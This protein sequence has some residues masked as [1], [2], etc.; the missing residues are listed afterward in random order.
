MGSP[1]KAELARQ[2]EAL[3][4]SLGRQ[5]KK[6]ARLEETLAEALE[7]QAATSEILRVIS[8]SPTDVQPV[9]D[10]IVANAA[11]LCDAEFS[12]V[13]RFEGGLLH[14]VAINNM[15]RE[16]TAAYQSLFP[17][18][19]G[20]HFAIGRAFVD[21]R[22]AHIEDVSKD[23]DY[24]PRTLDVLQRAA[25]Y[26]TYL[27]I[28]IMRDGVPIGA[29]GCGRRKVKPFTPA[30][31]E[32]VK[33]FADQAVIAIENVRLFNEAE[34][35]NR[36]LAEALEQQKATAEVLQV[37]SSSPTDIQPV[38]DTVAE[39]AAH[40]C[41]AFDAAI[42]RRDGDSLRLVAH[43]GA[44]PLG[45]LGQF[46]LPI[47]RGSMP[48]RSMLDGRT[49]HV[50]DLQV[51]SVEFP[52]GAEI[53]QRYGFRTT[54]CV[55]MMRD[56]AALGV[57]VLRRTE[58]EP[59]TA[60]QVALLQTF[61]DQAVIAIENVRLF[62]ELDARNSELRTA[63][64]QQTAT[65]ELLKVIGQSTF[66]LQPVFETLAENA[67]RLC[68]AE[69]ASIFR[70]DGHLLRIVATRNLPSELRAFL[71]QHPIPLARN[72]GSGRAALERRTIHIHDVRSDPEYAYRGREVAPYRTMVAIPMLRAAELLGVIVV[73]R[74]EV[75]PFTDGHIALMETFADQAAIAIENARLLT[76]L[77]AKNADL[78]EA[79][80][81]QTAT[82]EILRVISS[83][84]TDIR[85]VLDTVTE[86]AARLCE[87]VDTA[88]FFRDG[89]RLRLAAHHGAIVVGTI[90]VFTLPL[91]RGIVGARSVLD[92]RTIHVADMQTEGDEFPESSENA[93]RMGFRTILC[94]PLMREGV[95]IGWIQLR[96]TDMRLFTDRQVALLETFA[97]QAVIAIENV[98]LFTELEARNSE[99][100]VALEQQ[101]ATSEVLKVISRSTFDLQ[102][103][104]ETLVE[105]ASRL[106]GA[107]GALIARFDGEVFRFLAEYGASPEFSEYWRRHVIRPGRGSVVGRAILERRTVHIVDA[108]ADPEFEYYE[109][110][111]AGGYRS[112]LAVPMLRE[113]DLI[114]VFFMWRT[115]VRAFTDKQIDLVATFAD[116]AV[117]AIENSR[118]LTELTAKNADLTVALEQQTATSEILRVISSSP[119]DVQPVFDTIVR[120][121]VRLCDGLF[122]A[123]FLYD[124][125]LIDQVAQHNFSPEGLAEVRRLYPTRPGPGLGSTR[126]IMERAVVHIPDVETDPEYQHLGLTRAV[127]MR[128]GL[129]VPMLREGATVGVIMVSRA[130]PGRFADDQVE[131]LKTFADQ[132]VIAIQNVRLFKEL[133]ARNAELRVAL[134]QQTAT[135]EILR[136]ISSSPTDIQPVLDTVAESAARLCEAQ[137]AAIF[138]RDGDRLLLVA[139]HGP[140][141]YGPVGDFSLPLVPG[142]ANG[143]AVLDARTIHVADLQAAVDEFPDGS[144]TARRYGH[145]TVLNV[146]L[147]REG[148]AI[149]S[150]SLRRSEIQPFTEQQVALLQ[151]FADQAVIAIENV[152]LFNELQ[153]R[154][155]DLTEALEQQ[156]ATAEILRAISGSPTDVQPVF[157]AIVRS[158]VQLSGARFGALYRFDGTLLH[159]V[160]H[161]NLTPDALEALQ[162]AYPMR[163]SRAQVSGRAILGRAVAEIPD[164]WNDPEYLQDMARHAD[165][166]S[167]LAVPMLRADGAPIGAIVIQ[168]AEPGPF[169][170]GHVG[171]LK[172]FADQA[173]IAIE[174]VRLFT[175]LEAR[176]SELRV[177]LEQQTATSELL[178]VIGRSTFD[179]EPVFEALAE[180]AVR[181]CDAERAIIHRFDGHVLR[182]AVIHN[183]TPELRELAE[184]THLEPGRGTASGR[185]ALERRTVHIHDVQIDP[186]YTFEAARL[187][188]PIRTALAIP[189]LRA[190]EL[191]G[192]IFIY[193]HEV[194]PFSDS[195]I[196]LME[197]FADQAAIAIEN[198]R[199]LT[200]LQTKNT[201][202]TEALEQQTATSEILRVISSSPTDVQPVFDA[203]V[204]SAVR[205]CGGRFGTLYR[206]YGDM[207]D[208]VAYYNVPPE[209]YDLLRRGFPR[210]TMAGTSPHFRRALLEGTVESIRD[211]DTDTELS[212]RVLGF[213]RHHDMR[214][215]VMVPLRAQR[216]VVGVL[217]VGHREVAAFSDSHTAL[218]QTFADQAVIAIENVRLFRELEARNSELRVALEQ[219]TAT[220]EL[221]K[222]IG[223]STFDLQ[224]VF[225]MLAENAVRLCEAERAVILR[226]DGRL[227]H[228]V[229]THNVSAELRAYIE[230]NPIAPGRHS[231]AA[232]AALERRTIHIEDAQTDPEYTFGVR[233]IEPTRTTLGIPMLRADE[234]L[235]VILIYRHEVRPF[236]DG[237][238]VLMETFAD[239]AAI[240]IENARLLT[241]LQAKNTDLTEALEQQTA[242]SEI[243]R[244]ISSSPTDVQPVFDTIVRSAVQLS[245]AR[246]GLLYRFDGTLLHLV[247]HHGLTPEVL[248]SLQRA[249]PMR[250]TRAHISGRAVLG[251]AVAEIPDVREDAEYEPL[252]I[253]GRAGWRSLLSVP[254]LR[255]DGAPIGVIVIQRSEPG[256]FADNHVELLKTFADQAVI[257][258]QN[259]R[260]FTELEARNS[261]LRVAL[262]QQTAT[263][264]LLKV[265]GRSTFDLQPVF[266]TLA[267]NA[268]RLCGAEHAMIFRFDGQLLR[269]AAGHN[270][271][272]ERRAFLERNPIAPGRL[273]AAG[274]AALERRTIH[275]HDTQADPELTYP[276][277][278]QDFGATRTLLAI[279]M[280]KADELL[281]VI[282]IYRTEVR[283]FNEGHIALLETFADQAAIAIEN[284]RLLTEL[285]AKN[286]DLTE[287]LEQQTAT[288]EILRVI[289]QSQTDVQPVFDTIVVNSVNLCGARMGAVY[290]YDGKLL[291]M[292]AHH[293]YPPAVLEILQ[294]MHPR[295][296]QPDQA[297]G[298]AILTRVPVQIADMLADP[299][300]RT[301]V[302]VAG[303]WRSILSV[304]ML[305]DGDPIGA[306]VITRNQAG[307]FSEGNIQLLKTFADQAVIAI[308][309]V[310]LFKELESRNSE[311]RVALEQQ[312]ATSEL[313]KVIGRSTF[314]LQPV[315]ETLAENAVRLCE[316][317]RALI[318]RF[319]GQVLSV[320]ATH[321]ISSELSEFIEQNPTIA[322]GRAGGAARAALARRT[323]H[324]QDVRADA[325]Y[326]WG[327]GLVEPTRTVLA[328]PMLRADELLGVI[329]IYRYEVRPFSDGQI[330]LMETFADQAAIAIENARLL[331]ELQA[332]TGELTRSVQELRAL[333][334]VS[335]ALSSTL[336]LETVLSTIVSRA[337][338]LAGTDGGSVYEYDEPSEAFQQRATDNLDDEVVQV[339]RRTP[340]PRGEGVLGRMAV[341]REPVQIPDIAAEGAYRSPL[342]D[343]LVRT[344]TRALLAIPLL[345]EDRLVGG[346]TVNKK[347]PGEFPPH[348]IDLLK[349]FANQS[350]LAIQN[351]RLFREIEDKGR[352]LEAADRHKSEFLA[353]MSHEL[354]T[355]LNAIIGYSEMLQEDAADLGAEQL[356]DDL[357]KINAAGKH[358][359]ELIN[360][361]L[362][363]SKI[364]AGK[365]ELY[366]ESFDVA[367]LVRDI[368]AVIQPLAA[369]NSNRLDVRCP[370]AVGT[371]HAD[372]TKVRQALFNLLSNACKFTER[373]EVSL[374]VAREATDGQ[375]WMLF[376]VSDTGIG[377]TP[378]QLAKL[379]EAFSQADAATTRRYGG[380]GL[381]LALSRRLCRMMGGDVTVESEPDRGSTFTIRLPA[382]VAEAVQ[383]TPA[384]AAPVEGVPAGIGTVLVIDDE[385]AVRDLMQRFLTREG[386]R[387]VTASGGEDGLRR[388]RELRPDAITLDVM[389]PGID[390]WAVLSALKADPD[391]ADIPVV[392]LTIVDDKNLGYALGAADYLTKPIDRER[393]VTV[394]DKYRRDLPVL[395][396]DDDVAVRQLLRRMLE[397]EGYAVVEADNGRAALE[398]LRDVS[399]CCILLDLMMP[400]MDGF[401][402]VTEFRRREAWRAIPIVVITA[403]DL[404]HDDRERLNGYVQKILQKGTHGREQL[405]AE[406]RELV[407]TS[408]A[409]RRPRA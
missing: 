351:A 129:Y 9:F 77:Q 248:E 230:H 152:R 377:M 169:A 131:L 21:A 402:F 282:S 337:N 401:E 341:T 190:N 57:I 171:L 339:A 246:F 126:A 133:E 90:G 348:V 174:N 114:G 290:R 318:Y 244:V 6:S 51:E 365:M 14:L 89:D 125:E 85:P 173:V 29:I 202:L 255:A 233:D 317:E 372:L 273:A 95:A 212:P 61:A 305:H 136:V 335:Q 103:V 395:V 155:A 370:D 132:A 68:E 251:R 20:R 343:V 383:E 389:M 191:L 70:F 8:S 218:L 394:L 203:I 289:S 35:R 359:L 67:I 150:I 201:D 357:K 88:I 408:V 324:I 181:L 97:D 275:I 235:G 185:A 283:P 291:H 336:D 404:S 369:K 362:D 391:V 224:P 303:G 284:A 262:E 178:K 30:Q 250:P 48:G 149:G 258:I 63:L 179:L 311:L 345:R 390:G 350:A 319:D 96:R 81:Q 296:P 80:E 326:T 193:R 93:R 42:F 268:V 352:Q 158:A 274:R 31:I 272:P 378:D 313:L 227:L 170:A 162:R 356:T 321:N 164:V 99:L 23:P 277:Y 102:P 139:H 122:S 364:E 314:D 83:S 207:V 112:V 285:Q 307:P 2:L 17:R 141:A 65:S 208:C 247:A 398:R 189:M 198:A 110:Q 144:D 407:A 105:N 397:P 256:R 3:R 36:D 22:P 56:A 45:P 295:P 115:E 127:G 325:E 226:Y 76:E 108:L 260:L 5:S 300:Y 375:D 240:A 72:S 396:V 225:E 47:V 304:P 117:I 12:A 4:K 19:P 138:R 32:L 73:H 338:Q 107:E 59:F 120:S 78:T 358:L 328:V 299:V 265:I 301:E 71:E 384:P 309:N 154:N 87:A 37:I 346:L 266:E 137:D 172:T 177:A 62:K 242:T 302:A 100:R 280:L 206:R 156:T 200:E 219:Q 340:I 400:E 220:S 374:S 381:G 215:A 28:P 252:N 53:A 151:T 286:A 119:T 118:L 217:V 113:A 50:T 236:T 263:S 264:E 121:A 15:S 168:R 183:P 66:D 124:G 145:R 134:E 310:R 330:T 388:A 238:I 312:T 278:R 18:A 261:E 75:R 39:S 293:N 161:H 1:T 387:V 175:E 241:E 84:P 327:A 60:R 316:A 91:V 55:P 386:F 34:A 159:L 209:A 344:G 54:L 213:Y 363:L 298:R 232:R 153:T 27:G 43:H 249:Y 25:P 380:T 288:S 199:L 176:N 204:A 245:S 253:V 239:Q 186:E 180:N 109:A 306:I 403:K 196:A 211:I 393:L 167:L 360:A 163:P 334:E 116:Q 366:L 13:A 205:L 143:R 229:A 267:E 49:V 315:F 79:L 406:V 243:L 192:V 392:M 270:Y 146:P 182:P 287:A 101:T 405:L 329:I 147:L 157:L 64:E 223:R 98:R 194:R 399:P 257:A 409:R 24:D 281:G 94:V 354:R 130:R 148:V 279:P 7:R 216:E 276:T 259:V 26:R 297:S 371:M 69:Q 135:A 46:S 361:V 82:S 322:P 292:A 308:Q 376:S 41:E 237:Q 106:A 184:R 74:Y 228:V 382:Q 128:S 165:W 187:V 44:I 11:R 214:S 385:A 333:G 347:T 160:A 210:P 195:H 331:G 140:I 332:R 104:L 234:L 92:G 269:V 38:L 349:T 254:M 52:L 33:T 368:A 58:V 222:V 166:R 221:L 197:T 353:N 111:R 323:I 16:E 373:G 367:G 86:S 10:A 142:M 123:L 231:G 271:P 379:F 342:R 40:L 188:I 355:P 320:V 294:R